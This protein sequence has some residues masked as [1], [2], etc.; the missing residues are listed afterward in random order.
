MIVQ[1]TVAENEA[2]VKLLSSTA[3]IFGTTASI[4]PQ[5]IWITGT[6]LNSHKRDLMITL[7]KLD[8]ERTMVSVTI[9]DDNIGKS[10]YLMLGYVD[11]IEASSFGS[12]VC[13]V[14]ERIMDGDGSTVK[15]F[16]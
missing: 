13:W 10:I 4:S 9:T 6:G 1:D 11:T 14:I 8:F 3:R 15:V 7:E 2:L 5:S 12:L 16:E